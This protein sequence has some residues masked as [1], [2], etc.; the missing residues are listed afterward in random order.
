MVPIIMGAQGII[1]KSTD[2]RINKITGSSRLYEIQKMHFAELL[3]S[4]G[5]FCQ[6]VWKIS[7]QRATKNVNT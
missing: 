1:K 2:K 5:E 4:F 3:I 7:P 6:C